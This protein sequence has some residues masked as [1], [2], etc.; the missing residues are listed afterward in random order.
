MK[1]SRIA[2]CLALMFLAAGVQADENLPAVNELNFS[3]IVAAG[4]DDAD[5]RYLAGGKATF[6]LGHSFGAQIEGGIANDDYYG[7]GGHIFWRDPALGLIGL[8]GTFES[9]N[10]VDL[11]RTAIEA[12]AYLGPFTI[13]GV[14]GVERLQNDTAAYGLIFGTIYPIES[15]ALRAAGEFRENLSLARL[16]AEW[17][18][19]P[20]ELHEASLFAEAEYNS[21][22]TGQFLVG[23][24]LHL[25]EGTFSLQK[26]ERREDPPFAIF[27]TIPGSGPGAGNVNQ[28]QPDFICTPDLIA[29]EVCFINENGEV[30]F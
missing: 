19:L 29:E 13:G 5:S 6:P 8:V 7:L 25:G 15:L 12:E 10:D 17:Q 9:E 4:V 14:V 21:L 2:R 18:P 26:R 27:N 1:V 3:V 30:I 11:K 28:A 23:A 22:S 24:R 20:D 16:G